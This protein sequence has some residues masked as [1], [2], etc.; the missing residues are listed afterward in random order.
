MMLDQT[1]VHA[2]GQCPYQQKM[3][4]VIEKLRDLHYLTKG[5]LQCP[6]SAQAYVPRS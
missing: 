2:K 1:T 4:H 5:S 3:D 6:S